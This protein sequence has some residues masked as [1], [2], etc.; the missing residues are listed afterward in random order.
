V[1]EISAEAT[2]TPV[3]DESTHRAREA[4]IRSLL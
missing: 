1:P 2:L 4:E 3:L